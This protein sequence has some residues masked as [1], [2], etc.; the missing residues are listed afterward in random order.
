[1]NKTKI[2]KKLRRKTNPELVETIIHTKK[3]KAWLNISHMISTPRRKMV[4]INLDEID[5]QSKDKEFIVIP[6][7]V[8]GTGDLNKK[9]TLA[10]LS[11][12]TS[13]RDKLNKAKIE[14]LTIKEAMHKNPNAKEIKIINGKWKK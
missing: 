1:M 6:G 10:A 7:K 8:L 4:S 5:K 2:E 3:N 14:T 11:F 12:S 9:I 13:A